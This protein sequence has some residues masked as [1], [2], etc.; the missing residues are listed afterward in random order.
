MNRINEARKPSFELPQSYFE[1]QKAPSQ[2]THL[3]SLTRALFQIGTV[4]SA[5]RQ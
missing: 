4:C 5:L 2:M 1:P 3:H